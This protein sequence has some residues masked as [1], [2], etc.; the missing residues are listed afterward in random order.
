[1]VACLARHDVSHL[2]IDRTPQFPRVVAVPTNQRSKALAALA[3]DLANQQIYFQQ[4][5]RPSHRFCR[6]EDVTRARQ[7]D[8]I[9]VFQL[10]TSPEGTWTSGSDA[11]CEIQFWTQSHGEA[12][13]GRYD[14]VAPGSAIKPVVGSSRW[15]DIVSPENWLHRQH[16]VSGDVELPLLQTGGLPQV[17]QVTF[18]IDA[19]YT[20][21]DAS[22]PAWRA[23]YER[24]RAD[25]DDLHPLS[26]N[27]SRYASHDELRYSLRSIAMYANWVRH[28]Y[29][30]TDD[31]TP[32][33]LDTDDPRISVVDH[34]E[35]FEERGTLPTFNSHA[36]ESQLHH[37]PGLAEHFLY[38]NDDFLIGRGVRPNL[39]FRGNGHAV[40]YPSD[41]MI[42]LGEPHEMNGPFAAAWMNTARDLR[43]LLGVTV[44]QR[45]LHVP[46]ALNREVVAELERKLP[47]RFARTASCQFRSGRDASVAASMA[48]WYA[49]A[50]GRAEL[51]HLNF[52]YAEI[53]QPETPYRMVQ[54]LSRRGFDVMCLNDVAENGT[55]LHDSARV[56]HDFLETSYP[57]AASW[58]KDGTLGSGPTPA[59]DE[60]DFDAE[61]QTA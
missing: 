59:A 61:T 14:P 56:L 11:A 15:L 44:T 19:V 28:I 7:G 17:E 4:L 35:I 2:V 36:I 29:I 49:Y 34:R 51:G 55:E 27:A 37:I 12:P 24:A 25:H 57:F 46:Y 30:V 45:F 3:S 38:F 40:A 60:R 10:L 53:H 33:W 21:V 54:A 13:R 23:R 22:D 9:R 16:V 1:M 26:G 52:F 58:E 43:E 41:H 47:E 42:G 8:G 32:D 50:T 18:P 31:Q 5:E 6:V 20:W 39:F 48:G